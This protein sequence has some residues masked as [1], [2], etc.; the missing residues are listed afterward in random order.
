MLY[1]NHREK[2]TKVLGPGLRYV[3]WVQ[4]CKKDCIGCINPAGRPLDRNGYYISIET[5]FSEICATPNLTGITISGGEPFLQS[6]E[7]SKLIY[8]I[9]TES[10]LDIMVYTGY[11]LAELRRRNNAAVNAILSNIDI[12]VD[13]EYIE[14]KNNNTLYRGSDNQVIHF[15]SKKY[16]PF[17][18]KIESAHNRNIEFICRNDGELFIIGIPVKGFQKHFINNIWEAKK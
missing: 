14:E 3:I 15:M 8:L 13:G 1:I 16:L 2:S 11:T 7:L 17:K 4:G 6:E 18:D 5:L 12:L 10:Q 9:K